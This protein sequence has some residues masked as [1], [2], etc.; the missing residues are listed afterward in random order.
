MNNFNEQDAANSAEPIDDDERSRANQDIR[1]DGLFGRIPY[2][3]NE[4]IE[5]YDLHKRSLMATLKPEDA[6]QEC[7]AK[8]IV[9]AVWRVEGFRMT[10][11]QR[12]THDTHPDRE[13]RG[14]QEQR[15]LNGMYKALKTLQELQ[16]QSKVTRAE[17]GNTR[18]DAETAAAANVAA[19]LES[20]D[21]EIAD[22]KA[23]LTTAEKLKDQPAGF[24]PHP[25]QHPNAG[26]PAGRIPLTEILRKP[27]ETE[28]QPSEEEENPAA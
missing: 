22:L 4:K 17:E 27:A 8:I 20:K 23:R 15:V 7:L 10:E 11:A 28:K 3:Q 12:N 14:R 26:G 16:A 6:L 9:D 18:I 13:S 21:K 24:V 2:S 19:L 25:S 5:A 1:V